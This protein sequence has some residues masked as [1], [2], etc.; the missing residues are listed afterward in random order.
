MTQELKTRIITAAILLLLVFFLLFIASNFWFDLALAVLLL[1]AAWEWT[2]L[3]QVSDRK[4][5]IFYLALTAILILSALYF[6]YWVHLGFIFWLSALLWLPLFPG[7]TERL[8]ADYRLNLLAGWLILI[9]AWQALHLLHDERQLILLLLIIIWAA[10][11]G[12]YFSGRQFG[13]IKLASKVSPGKT[14]EGAA[15][16]ALLAVVAGMVYINF[17]SGLHFA[18]IGLILFTVFM[19]VIGDLVESAY[20]R[21]A[22]LKDSSNILPG[23]GGILD[24]IDSLTA[25]APAFYLAY[26]FLYFKS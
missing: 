15:G 5:K 11:I 3:A 1:L 18:S 4:L 14:L 24:R 20:K 21:Q 7:K 17:I 8:F 26:N 13:N 2:N 19:S 9:P 12:A 25:A 16:G 23:H 22:G 10:D 6:N